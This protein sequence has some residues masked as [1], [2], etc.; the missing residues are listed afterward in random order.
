MQGR[1]IK[2]VSNLYTVDTSEGVFSCVVRKRLKNDVK[3]VV[4]DIVE[5]SGA[6]DAYVI[7]DLFERKNSLIRPYVS[8][9]DVAVIVISPK[10]KADW[11]LVDKV[12]VNAI[13][14]GIEPIIVCNKC[15]IEKVDMTDYIGFKTFY[16]SAKNNEGIVPLKKYLSQ[17]TVCLIGQSAVGKSSLINAM[18]N[19]NLQTGDLAKKTERGRHTTRQT[20][21]LKCDD[22]YIIDTCGFSLLNT[23]DI[24]PEELKL[25]YEE[26]LPFSGDCRYHGCTHIGEPGCAVMPHIG[27]EI[28]KGR[29]ERYV[30]IFKE[31]EEKRRKKYE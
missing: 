29:Y 11:I 10:P 12:I 17:K 7:D 16:T 27:K 19:A 18:A 22:F 2:I 15:D 5:I 31:L 28:S 6:S 23:I 26:F 25:Y 8:N 9:I 20:E 4:G 3:L 24:D 30:A 14:E 1:I 21:L 13:D